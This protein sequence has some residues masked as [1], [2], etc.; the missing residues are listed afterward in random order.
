MKKIFAGLFVAILFAAGL[1]AFSGSAQAAPDCPYTGCIKTDTHVDSPGKVK[2][3][4][5]AEVCVRVTSDGDGRPKG[6]VSVEI[7]R[8]KGGYSFSNGRRYNDNKECFTTGKLDQLGDY[9]VKAHFEANDNSPYKN[10]NN[11]ASFKVTKK[12]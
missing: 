7:S 9:S 6:T 1:V 3:G 10:S 2:Q 11:T 12:G 4:K 5:R 8:D